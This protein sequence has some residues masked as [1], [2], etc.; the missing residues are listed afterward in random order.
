MRFSLFLFIY[1]F[2]KTQFHLTHFTL[3]LSS[4]E[5]NTFIFK[6]PDTTKT[7]KSKVVAADHVL[8]SQ[9]EKE[10]QLRSRR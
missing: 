2:N 6:L 9:N 3:I 10:L 4:A 8:N 7:D 5:R 1:N